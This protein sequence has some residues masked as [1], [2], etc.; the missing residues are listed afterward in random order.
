MDWQHAA[1]TLHCVLGMDKAIVAVDIAHDQETFDAWDVPILKG[2]LS[3]CT[4]VKM[5]TLGRGRK[6]LGENFRCPGASEVFRFSEPG[7]EALSGERL[8]GFGLYADTETA[9]AVQAAMPRLDAP[10]LGITTTP[11]ATAPRPP[12][13]LLLI[14]DAYQA[15]RLVQGWAYHN[16]P[17]KSLFLVGNRGICAEAVARPLATGKPN[18]TPLCANTRHTAK[19]A[20]GDLGFGLPFSCLESLADGLVNTIPAVEPPDRK[21]GLLKR[22]E[23]A[24]VDLDLPSG[25]CY[26][27]KD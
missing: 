3:F 11:V 22:C 10:C 13:S 12:Q 18:L 17:L 25:T 4:M 21:E 24:G 26:F 8:H 27:M 1:L 20:D 9:R 14:V 6:A 19:W 16:G 23:K 7:P 15:M 2:R 5:A